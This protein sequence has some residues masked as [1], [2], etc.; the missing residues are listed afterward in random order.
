M[1]PLLIRPFAISGDFWR[2]RGASSRSDVSRLPSQQDAAE[3]IRTASITTAVLTV[4]SIAG[5]HSSLRSALGLATDA[6]PPWVG[7]YREKNT[8]KH[9]TLHAL[10]LLLANTFLP[11]PVDHLDALI[12]HGL[13]AEIEK[14]PESDR[15]TL[16]LRPAN[17]LVAIALQTVKHLSGADERDGVELIPVPTVRKVLRGGGG[18][19]ATKS[20]EVLRTQVSRSA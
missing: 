6:E 9:G 17:L 10:G 19:R 8:R 16:V 2:L 5:F 12:K 3:P 20:L 7:T 18:Y 13:E 11:D 14:D 15:P 4:L 1:I